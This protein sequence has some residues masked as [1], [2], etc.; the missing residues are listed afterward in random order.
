MGKNILKWNR[1]LGSFSFPFFSTV[2]CRK[3]PAE[4][5]VSLGEPGPYIS[6]R[7]TVIKQFSVQS[8]FFLSY[9]CQ[10]L[11]Y[12]FLAQTFLC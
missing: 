12:T 8:D 3:V 5:R 6:P 11:L 7:L 4:L 9:P 1:D 10:K 2:E